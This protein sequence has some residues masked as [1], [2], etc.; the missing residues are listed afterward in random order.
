MCGTDLG[1]Q[2]NGCYVT[3]LPTPTGQG[4]TP[5][6]LGCPLENVSLMNHKRHVA[7]CQTGLAAEVRHRRVGQTQAMPP[8]NYNCP[9]RFNFKVSANINTAKPVQ[10]ISSK[11]HVLAPC[12][13]SIRS[14]IATLPC[15]FK[16]RLHVLRNDEVPRSTYAH[17][18]TILS[19]SLSSSRRTMRCTR[20]C[21]AHGN[22]L[23]QTRGS[24]RRRRAC[25]TLRARTPRPR[26]IARTPARGG[27]MAYDDAL[28]AQQHAPAA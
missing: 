20:G 3:E 8:R 21:S 2:A 10:P 15:V 14:A 19:P 18:L 1:R 4:L 28:V 9:P 22:T 11:N 23:L 24:S 6:D 7:P 25:F 27:V 13:I 17:H 12:R 5:F 16:P 26:Y